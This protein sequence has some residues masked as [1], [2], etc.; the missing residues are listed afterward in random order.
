MMQP[1]IDAKFKGYRFRPVTTVVEAG[2]LQA[3]FDAIGE[4]NSA[5]INAT[6]GGRI[7]LPPT[8][9]F[10]LE[11]LGADSPFAFVE[12]INIDIGD[13]LHADQSFTY[14]LPVYVGESLTY[15]GRVSDIFEKKNGELTFVIQD[16]DVF[17][18]E[19]RLIAEM[20]RTFVIKRTA[21]SS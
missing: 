4:T 20:R 17:N 3:F 9:L 2:R 19:H 13:I 15:N 1:A 8:Y 5:M 10:C 7:A 21:V 14:H 6:A 12:E 11:M 16:V 18:Q